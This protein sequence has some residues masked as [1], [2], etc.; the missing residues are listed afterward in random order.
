MVFGLSAANS[1]ALGN[2]PNARTETN[3]E[4]RENR[5]ILTS[6]RLGPGAFPWRQEPV[7][8]GGIWGP[9]SAWR[10]DGPRALAAFVKRPASCKLKS[11]LDLFYTAATR[12]V[13]EKIFVIDRS[14]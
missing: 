9:P 10:G 11:A 4:R 3:R 6:T 12:R 5:V 7:D 8:G 1:A 14:P 2:R 13:N